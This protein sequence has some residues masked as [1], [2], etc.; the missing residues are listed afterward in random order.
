MLITRA[1]A[2]ITQTILTLV[3]AGLAVV[4]GLW[5]IQALTA[6]GWERLVA[7]VTQGFTLLL[8]VLHPL[9]GLSFWIIL[10]PFAPFWHMDLHLGAGIPDISLVRL[11][12][13][14]VSFVLLAQLSTGRYSLPP[15]GWTEVGMLLFVGGMLLAAR[16][17]LNGVIPAVQVAFDAYV[18]PLLVYLSARVL[19]TDEKRLQWMINVFLVIVLYIAI[20][21]LHESWTGDVWF[22]PW[23][24]MG[25]YTTGLRRVTGLLG[26]PAY[27]ATI[28]T[29]SLPLAIYRYVRASSRW[30]QWAY[31][32]LVGLMVTTV[33]FL[34]N[35]A[36]YLAAFV[37]MLVMAVRFPRWRRVFLPTLL[38]GLVVLAV[39]WGSFTR[40][41]FYVR[42]L[43]NQASVRDRATAIRAAWTLWK[44]SPI[45]GIGYPNYGI[46]TLQR[47]FFEKIDDKWIPSP[48]NTFM[49]ILSQAGLIAFSGYTLMLLGMAR[50]AVMRYRQLREEVEGRISGLWQST[51]GMG[52]TAKA[53]SGW[54][55]VALASLL[56]YIIMILTID[57]DP[58]H[59]SNIVFYTLMGSILGYMAHTHARHPASPEKR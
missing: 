16:M 39:M 57:A 18:V 12:V 32:G 26:N 22:Y 6:R 33:G 48:H 52:T 9:M 21:A 17:A 58:A 59:F 36:G 35:R 34:Y 2:Y 5:L 54:A 43:N 31:L 10:A 19:V 56:A 53:E 1:R 51:L 55:I 30:E 15:L 11:G 38:A 7:L 24:R 42:R 41:E 47:G 14:S 4:V 49:G 44:E 25:L 23:G 29:V 27:H 8:V 28:M 40:T 46:V 20:I 3:Q 50:E 45:F 13:L 37:V